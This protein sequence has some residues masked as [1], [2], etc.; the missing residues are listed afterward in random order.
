MNPGITQQQQ[1]LDDE[2]GIGDPDS[3]VVDVFDCKFSII[4]S[5]L[6]L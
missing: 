5:L 1:K 2:D 3:V 6:L 4:L